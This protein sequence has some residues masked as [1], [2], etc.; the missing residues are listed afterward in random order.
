MTLIAFVAAICALAAAAVRR[1]RANDEIGKRFN[2][3]E[4]DEAVILRGTRMLLL[5]ISLV[6]AAASITLFLLLHDTSLPMR[7][8]G[9]WSFLFGTIGVVGVCASL[10]TRKNGGEKKQ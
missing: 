6:A 3:D 1:K 4:Y 10:F 8:F 7:I 2:G 9:E 5:T